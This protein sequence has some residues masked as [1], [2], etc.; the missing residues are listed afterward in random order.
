MNDANA[1][2][3]FVVLSGTHICMPLVRFHVVTHS[4]IQSNGFSSDF[5]LSVFIFF[6]IFR[7]FVRSF[8]FVSVESVHL[9]SFVCCLCFA[10]CFIIAALSERSAIQCGTPKCNV[11]VSV[12]F[13][14]T[15]AQ[16]N[17]DL[18][19]AMHRSQ[20]MSDKLQFKRVKRSTHQ[21]NV[22]AFAK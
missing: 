13:C 21:R 4:T 5:F 8:F 9:H 22:D 11:H 18:L 6:F 7:S 14:A 12:P 20:N 10:E 15:H 1:F 16:L 2:C 17:F 3:R 19:D